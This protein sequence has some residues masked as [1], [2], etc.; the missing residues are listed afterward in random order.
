MYNNWCF[1]G[2]PDRSDTEL[3]LNKSKRCLDVESQR[4]SNTQL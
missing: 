3:I 4:T 2:L 1:G